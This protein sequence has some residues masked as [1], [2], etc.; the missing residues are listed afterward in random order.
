VGV[1]IVARRISAWRDSRPALT[2]AV[3]IEQ[4]IV[5]AQASATVIDEPRQLITV[6]C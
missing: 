3:T 1:Q 4:P 5:H 6:S 2:P